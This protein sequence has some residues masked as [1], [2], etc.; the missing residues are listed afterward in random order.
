MGAADLR[1][2][3]LRNLGQCEACLPPLARLCILEP[4]TNE[5]QAGACWQEQTPCHEDD[6]IEPLLHISGWQHC[7]IWASAK[8][9]CPLTLASASCSPCCT[10]GKRCDIRSS[11]APAATPQ[12][13]IWGTHAQA[14]ARPEVKMTGSGSNHR[15]PAARSQ[16]LQSAAQVRA[17]S[18]HKRWHAP[19]KRLPRAQPC[20][21]HVQISARC[22]APAAGGY[23]KRALLQHVWQHL[24]QP[25][26]AALREDQRHAAGRLPLIAVS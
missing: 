23:G 5:P 9:A 20:R 10:A 8:A 12:A 13:A 4:L 19:L 22:T 3:V 6:M 17:G 24:A 16:L 7:A 26:C 15:H 11:A 1:L 18:A 21:Q 25:V 2:A 14:N